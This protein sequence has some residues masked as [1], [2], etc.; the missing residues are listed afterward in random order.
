MALALS[1]PGNA[2]PLSIPR[3]VPHP[4]GLIEDLKMASESGCHG[5]VLSLW[6]FAVKG[7]DRDVL[8]S[9]TLQAADGFPS[10]R[11][12]ALQCEFPVRGS[13]LSATL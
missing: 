4:G 1:S 6:R 11:R 3:P 9:V 7:L 8:D 5:D 10:D 12:W 13:M 2:C